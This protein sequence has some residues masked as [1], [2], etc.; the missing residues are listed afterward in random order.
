MIDASFLC[1]MNGTN[2]DD[3]MMTWF[4]FLVT[5]HLAY[6]MHMHMHGTH[7][8]YKTSTSKYLSGL[9]CMQTDMN[10]VIIT[11]YIFGY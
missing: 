4:G 5:S 2:A 1:F 9:A 7:D 6:M 8:L 3:I 11:T 10:L